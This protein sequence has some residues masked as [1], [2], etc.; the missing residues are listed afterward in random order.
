ME[1]LFHRF[2]KGF[3]LHRSDA[4]G[5]SAANSILDIHHLILHMTLVKIRK[6]D[7]YHDYCEHCKNK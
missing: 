2:D 6:Y 4:L 7:Q 5:I 1:V 3:L